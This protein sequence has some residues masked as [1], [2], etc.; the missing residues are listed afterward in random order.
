MKRQQK[1]ILI[2][3]GLLDLLAAAGLGYLIWHTNQPTPLPTP[4]VA[5]CIALIQK[6]IPGYLSPAIAWE[7]EHLYLSITA[8]Y[9]V[10][11][12]PESSVQLLW[13][14]LDALAEASRVGCSLPSQVTLTAVAQGTETILSHSAKV[15][16]E[17]IRAWASGTLSQEALSHETL[18]RSVSSK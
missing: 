6:K 4:D 17:E 18:Y 1:L 9:D 10:T 5:P 15:S 3:F 11:T 7:Q 2:I 12:P 8:T 14:S 16:G 13:T